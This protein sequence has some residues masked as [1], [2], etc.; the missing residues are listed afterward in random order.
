MR[1]ITKNDFANKLQKAG[2]AVQHQKVEDSFRASINGQHV[3]VFFNGD[4]RFH[5][6]TVL[7]NDGE[8][9]RRTLRS[10]AAVERHLGIIR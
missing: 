9:I 10:M 8:P 6:A 7:N 3:E 5:D 2:V 1:A 4:D